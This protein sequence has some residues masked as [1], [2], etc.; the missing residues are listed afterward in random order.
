MKD[1]NSS[2]QF[3]YVTFCCLKQNTL[4]IEAYATLKKG[5]YTLPAF[6]PNKELAPTIVDKIV[7]IIPNLLTIVFMTFKNPVP[8][9]I[10]P[11]KTLPLI[12][13]FDNCSNAADADL[14]FASNEDS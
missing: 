7:G 1:I 2:Q 14:V 13:V 8:V 4:S 5:A 10:N 9:S 6:L 11:P 12:I 3:G